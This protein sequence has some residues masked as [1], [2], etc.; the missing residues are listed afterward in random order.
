[1]NVNPLAKELCQKRSS[2]WQFLHWIF[3]SCLFHS[4][5]PFTAHFPFTLHSLGKSFY[6]NHRVWSFLVEEEIAFLKLELKVISQ[7]LTPLV[8]SFSLQCFSHSRFC[9]PISVPNN[10]CWVVDQTAMQ[11][12]QMKGSGYLT[13]AEFSAI[14]EKGAQSGLHIYSKSSED[15]TVG[16]KLSDVRPLLRGLCS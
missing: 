2:Y 9:Y 10:T 11:P 15:N 5:V 6:F 16:C 3:A 7:N 12:P 14:D 4:I 1:M 8:L 13:F